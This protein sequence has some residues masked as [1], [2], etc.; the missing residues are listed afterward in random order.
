MNGNF[1]QKEF[2]DG[3]DFTT[4]TRNVCLL[5]EYVTFEKEEGSNI[6]KEY[7]YKCYKL[8]EGGLLLHIELPLLYPEYIGF[9]EHVCP[10]CSKDRISILSEIKPT[11]EGTPNFHAVVDQLV[12]DK[13]LKLLPYGYTSEFFRILSQ[14][15]EEDTSES[16]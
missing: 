4:Q 9:Q 14:S 10:A 13:H 2:Y 5:C 1:E 6:C 15:L 8:K 11:G 16:N 3:I 7:N 12:L